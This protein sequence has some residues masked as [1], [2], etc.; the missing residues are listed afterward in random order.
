[1]SGVDN[2]VFA[3]GKEHIHELAAVA[4]DSARRSA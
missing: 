2:E 4:L 1:M 3:T